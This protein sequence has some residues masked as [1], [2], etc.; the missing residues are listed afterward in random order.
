MYVLGSCG[1][2]QVGCIYINLSSTHHTVC[3]DIYE[4]INTHH[5]SHPSPYH[6][7]RKY[8]KSEKTKVPTLLPSNSRNK[9]NKI[10]Y[11][12]LLPHPTTQRNMRPKPP[13]LTPKPPCHLSNQPLELPLQ[14]M[15]PR[16]QEPYGGPR[17]CSGRISLA[18]ISKQV[19]T[20]S[21]ELGLGPNA[22]SNSSGTLHCVCKTLTG[23]APRAWMGGKW[24]WTDWCGLVW[25]EG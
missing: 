6:K 19:A 9:G 2:R 25:I 7:S 17:H 22:K 3:I 15:P 13:M 11:S 8:H 18:G 5:R 23:D 20:G 16:R 21:S 24:V 4:Y 10:K 12:Q 14:R 1:K